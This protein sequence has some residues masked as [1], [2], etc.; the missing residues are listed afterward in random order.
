M[1]KRLAYC[2]LLLWSATACVKN[3]N[4]TPSSTDPVIVTMH[5]AGVTSNYTTGNYLSGASYFQ[6]SYNTVVDG[7][8]TVSALLHRSAASDTTVSLVIPAG[9]KNI[10][11]QDSTGTVNYYEKSLGYIGLVTGTTAV[12]IQCDNSR[13]KFETDADTSTTN[14]FTSSAYFLVNTDTISFSVQSYLTSFVYNNLKVYS[15]N[16]QELITSLRFISDSLQA[17][18]YQGQQIRLPYM[19]F[20]YNGIDHGTDVLNN[21]IAPGSGS[22]VVL[23][24]TRVGSNNFDATF[25]GKVWSAKELDTLV[26]RQGKLTNIKLP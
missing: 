15:L 2:A 5:V 9:Y 3:D 21:D 6:I 18:L 16:M 19:R 7:N 10:I 13:Y 23:N 24:V 17:A 20:S 12:S 22:T 4:T 8:I 1:N 25:S 14:N 26:I 11:R